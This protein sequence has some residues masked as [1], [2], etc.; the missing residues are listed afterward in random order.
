MSALAATFRRGASASGAASHGG[1]PGSGA[2]GGARRGGGPATRIPTLL[3]GAMVLASV[4][5]VG[6][7]GVMQTSRAASAGYE[8]RNLE[9]ERDGTSAEVRLLEADV[10]SMT[11]MERVRREAVTRLGM[12]PATQV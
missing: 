10:A 3:L 8:I 12:V 1:A 11:Q 4:A 5:G 9:Q 7:F 2:H 6:V